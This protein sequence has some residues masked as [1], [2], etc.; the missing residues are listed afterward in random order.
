MVLNVTVMLYFY[1][2]NKSETH[3][4]QTAAEALNSFG[5]REQNAGYLGNVNSTGVN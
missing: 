2:L 1:H 5:K 4:I 3:N